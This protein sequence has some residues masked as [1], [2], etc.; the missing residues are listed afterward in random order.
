MGPGASSV[1]NPFIDLEQ[2]IVTFICS[3]YMDDRTHVMS[4]ALLIALD[5]SLILLSEERL[6]TQYACEDFIEAC[7]LPATPSL[8]PSPPYKFSEDVSADNASWFADAL[9]GLPPIR[10]IQLLLHSLLHSHAAI[11]ITL[12]QESQMI[13]FILTV[14][15]QR[16]HIFTLVLQRTNPPLLFSLPTGTVFGPLTLADSPPSTLVDYLPPL[17]LEEFPC[18]TSNLIDPIF[19]DLSPLP[20]L[21]PTPLPSPSLVN[22]VFP[23]QL[24]S[25]CRCHPLSLTWT[26]LHFFFFLRVLY[27]DEYLF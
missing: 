6:F 11:P 2:S 27:L 24:V 23:C 21:A 16:I 12:V 4:Q 25:G 3:F 1:V 5:S 13:T 22:C 7:S 26:A 20:M 9:L 17:C 8:S 14:L 10:C 18:L 15:L 19:S